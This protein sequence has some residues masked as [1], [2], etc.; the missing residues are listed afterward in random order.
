MFVVAPPVFQHQTGPHQGR[1]GGLVRKLVAQAAVEAFD[2]GVLHGLTRRNLVPAELGLLGPAQ[3]RIAG[4]LR[5]VVADN[6]PG[7]AAGADQQIKLTREP[8][9]EV[10]ATAARHSRVRSSKTARM[11][12]RRP[13]AN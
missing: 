9:S 1:E 5:A 12:K 13:Q 3:D 7:P 10:S 6:R 2:E 4:Q 11:R 8:E